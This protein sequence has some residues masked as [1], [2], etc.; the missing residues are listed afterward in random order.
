ML[1]LT[2]RNLRRLDVLVEDLLTGEH[3]GSQPF[4]LPGREVDLGEVILDELDD[5]SCE[6]REL[7]LELRIEVDRG[8][9][10]VAGDHDQLRRMVTNLLSNALEFSE[11]GGVLTVCLQALGDRVRLVVADSGI[12]IPLGEQDGLFT[13]F[14]RSS[15]ARD[16]SIEGTGLGLSIVKNI[17][18]AHQGS[19][20]VRSAEGLGTRFTVWLPRSAVGPEQPGPNEFDLESDYPKVL[21]APSTSAGH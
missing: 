14:H 5:C 9:V 21:L 12:G 19:I 20:E 16:R 1:S 7:E 13:R 11:S 6:V 8:S 18:E 3:T 4:G 2:T 15:L 17:V 10:M